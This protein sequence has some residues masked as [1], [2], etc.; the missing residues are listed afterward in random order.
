MEKTFSEQDILDLFEDF[1][2]ENNAYSQ[3][4]TY[5]QEQNRLSISDLFSFLNKNYRE[6]RYKAAYSLIYGC[7]SFNK[8]IEGFEFWLDLHLK[9]NK[10]L[11]EYLKNSC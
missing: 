2:L 4:V 5:I 6:T 8:T 1:L 3:Y 7:V 10:I 11:H 9:W